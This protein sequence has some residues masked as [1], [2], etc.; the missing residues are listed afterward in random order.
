METCFYSRISIFA[1]RAFERS[2][3]A[4]KRDYPAACLRPARRRKLWEARRARAALATAWR[5][6]FSGG[7]RSAA[8]RFIFHNQFQFSSRLGFRRLLALCLAIIPRAARQ[9]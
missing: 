5:L 7:T 2:E 8:G 9:N 4:L 1:T 3:S 6:S